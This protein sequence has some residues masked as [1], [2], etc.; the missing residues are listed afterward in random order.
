MFVWKYVQ[1]KIRQKP[2]LCDFLLGH[3][4]IGEVTAGV[5]DLPDRVGLM[6]KA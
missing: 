5:D 4:N 2:S 3:A 1:I 6:V